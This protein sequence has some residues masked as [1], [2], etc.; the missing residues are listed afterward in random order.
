[1]E[2][3]VC[4]QENDTLSDVLASPA[5]QSSMLALGEETALPPLGHVNLAQSLTPHSASCVFIAN[6]GI[7]ELKEIMQLSNYLISNISY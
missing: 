2:Q 3:N 7:V 6:M 5:R 1:M 4:R